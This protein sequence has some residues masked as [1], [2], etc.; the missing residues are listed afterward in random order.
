VSEGRAVGFP[1]D[2][3]EFPTRKTSAIVV[4][5]HPVRSAIS[6][7]SSRPPVVDGCVDFS[8]AFVDFSTLRTFEIVVWSHPVL[9]RVVVLP[10]GFLWPRPAFPTMRR[11]VA[12]IDG[13]KIK[14]LFYNLI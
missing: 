7:A 3:V 10:L 1:T 9:N 11:H 12:G 2:F 6:R 4:K 13:R 8:T 5:C 14:S